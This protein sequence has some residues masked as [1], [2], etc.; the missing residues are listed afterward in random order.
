MPAPD[1][2]PLATDEYRAA[3]SAKGLALYDTQLKP[4]LEP[5]RNGEYVVLHVDNG[6]YT[7]GRSFTEAKRAMR[8]RYPRDGRLIGLKIGTEPEYGLAVRL[9]TADTAAGTPK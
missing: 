9:L 4:V 8:R 2:S 3:M 7:V 6:D 5:E 1:A